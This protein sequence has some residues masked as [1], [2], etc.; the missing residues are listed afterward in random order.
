MPSIEIFRAGTHQDA[1]GQI[2]TIAPQ[3]LA[4]IAQSYT[5]ARHHA[6]VVIGH[7]Q[8]NAP[9]YGWVNKLFVEGDS[10]MAEIDPTA[11]LTDLFRRGLYKKISASFYLPTADINPDKPGFYLRHIGVLGAMPPAIKG[12]IDPIFNDGEKDY[13]EFNEIPLNPQ[14]T[15]EPMSENHTQELEALKAE[16]AKLKAQMLAAQKAQEQKENADF[17]EGL[18]KDGKLMPAQKDEL[19]SILNAD[20]TT[21]DFSETDFKGRLKGF[22]STLPKVVDFAEKATKDQSA[23][24]EDE[25]VQYAEGTNPAVIEMDKKVRAYM[26]E[27]NC[28]YTQAFNANLA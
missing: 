17:A 19:L 22:L 2:L 20:H 9:A 18:I 3:D 26:K 12:M 16:N 23:T 15:G 4:Q 28:T 21:A 24:P 14:P 27:H 6:P 13:C 11:E 8:D 10:L 1:N 7:P 5:P 25:T